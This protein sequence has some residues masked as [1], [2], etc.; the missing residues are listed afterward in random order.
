[1][2]WMNKKR[3][4]TA[5]ILVIILS[6]FT[7]P[8]TTV[9]ASRGTVSMA[10]ASTSVTVIKGQQATIAVTINPSSE[11]ELIGC[12]CGGFCGEEC[13]YRPDE[14]CVCGGTETRNYIAT[15]S[16]QAANQTIA[17][18]KYANGTITITGY[19][20][21]QTTIQATA[22]LRHYDNSPVQTITV[23]VK[24]ASSANTGN[25]GSSSTGTSGQQNTSVVAPGSQTTTGTNSSGKT[26]ASTQQGQSQSEGSSEN[27]TDTA[28]ESASCAVE[29]DTTIPIVDGAIAGKEE[30]LT[31]LGQDKNITFRRMDGAGNMVYSWTFN[32]LDI[33]DPE[34]FDMGITIAGENGK[35]SSDVEGIEKA[36]Y[37]SFAHSGALPGKAVIQVY[38]GD[39]YEDGD[40]LTLYYYNPDSKKSEKIASDLKVEKGYAQFTIT[41]C[42]EYFFTPQAGTT[43]AADAAKQSGIPVA[44]IIITIV[45]VLCIGGGSA[46]FLRK[47]RVELKNENHNDMEL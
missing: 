28:S 44:A 25:S 39:Y 17:A 42:S 24:D 20:V 27:T 6:L 13:C 12:G 4:I 26:Q 41:H 43:K 3:K 33:S 46:W 23:T 31:I 15:M 36:L 8:G 16:F 1:M 19:N 35:V 37:L 9:L 30:L 38:V 32:G 10:L 18:A 11:D 7:L 14:G 34:D 21:G 5:V 45:V 29:S 22:N 47:K 2:K 40:T